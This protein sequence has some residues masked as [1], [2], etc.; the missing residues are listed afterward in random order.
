MVQRRREQLKETLGTITSDEVLRALSEKLMLT[1]SA[2]LG[3]LGTIRTP[4]HQL[5]VL[6]GVLSAAHGFD[7]FASWFR[8]IVAPLVAAISVSTSS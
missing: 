7:D 3:P 2:T 8:P 1:R 5:K 6:C 4:E